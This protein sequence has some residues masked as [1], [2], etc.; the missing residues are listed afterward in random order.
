M[1]LEGKEHL[2]LTTVTEWRTENGAKYFGSDRILSCRLGQTDR[3]TPYN[4]KY[5]AYA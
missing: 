5:L 4:N 2:R 3:Q 1:E